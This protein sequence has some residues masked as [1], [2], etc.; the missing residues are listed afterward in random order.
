MFELVKNVYDVD[1]V[2]CE[3]W[4][5]GNDVIEVVDDGVGMMFDDFI[6]GW[7]WIGISFKGKCLELFKFGCL[8]IGEKGIGRF[9]VRF[10]GECLDLVLIVFD[11]ECKVNM[12]LEV[13]FVWVDFD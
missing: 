9:V 4:I 12:W 5:D 6:S 11:R 2:C 8:I 3:I 10:L 1:V 7:M 13:F